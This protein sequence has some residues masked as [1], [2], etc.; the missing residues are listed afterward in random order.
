MTTSGLLVRG[1][2]LAALLFGATIAHPALAQTET[3]T[4]RGC[5]LRNDTYTC[6]RAVFEQ[7]LAA[8]KTVAIE[9]APADAVALQAATKLVQQMGKT[10]V[11]REEHPD[12][13]VLLIPVDPSGVQFALDASLATL[14][15]FAANPQ[16]SG[17]G[18]LVWAETLT[19]QP[20]LPWPQIVG[21]TIQQFRGH[22]HIKG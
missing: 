7:A 9:T 18:D 11:P 16:V 2:T 13:T 22:F 10:V 14:R 19:G 1:A 17:R 15:F 12:M 20:G 21:R 8:A 4:S 3:N 5:T 6:D